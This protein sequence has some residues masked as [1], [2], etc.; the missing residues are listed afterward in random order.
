M[1]IETYDQYKVRL[2]KYIDGLFNSDD[3]EKRNSVFS[4][5]LSEEEEKEEQLQEWYKQYLKKK[6]LEVRYGSYGRYPLLSLVDLVGIGKEGIPTDYNASLIFYPDKIW[7]DVKL[8]KPIIKILDTLNL[9]KG[10]VGNKRVDRLKIWFVR[11]MES[12]RQQMESHGKVRCIPI[13]WETWIKLA[14]ASSF[15]QEMEIEVVR[16][17]LLGR[18]LNHFGEQVYK[19]GDFS[20]SYFIPTQLITDSSEWGRTKLSQPTNVSQKPSEQQVWLCQSYDGV[21][22]PTYESVVKES[23]NQL[24]TKNKKG[25]ILISHEE[26]ELLS[27][28]DQKKHVDINKHLEQ[29]ENFVF[30]SPTYYFNGRMRE[31]ISGLPSWIRDNMVFMDGKPLEKSDYKALH[32]NLWYKIMYDDQ[33]VHDKTWKYTHGS[34]FDPDRNPE[35]MKLSTDDLKWWKNNCCGDGHTKIAKAMLRFEGVKN[36][37]EQQ[38]LDAREAVK[39]ES[40]SHYNNTLYMMSHN[41]DGTPNRMGKFFSEEGANCWNY[42]R[43]TKNGPLGHCNTSRILT[44][45]ESKLIQASIKILKD[46]GIKVVY[47]HDCLMSI[48]SKEVVEVMNDVAEE[49]NVPTYATT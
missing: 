40:L 44:R 38:V 13:H 22:I 11:Q 17:G 31:C 32:H 20:R 1:A 42:I 33:W 37:T 5:M 29:Y 36:P 18:Q 19:K 26:F 15:Y 30:S 16:S 2:L 27:E 46:K 47:V 28:D 49:S 43:N 41:A 48:K 14:G 35:Q 34:D 7:H 9:G 4:F 25:K 45:E 24:G 21:E 3:Q 39:T 10:K 12:H 23:V 8:P 6:E